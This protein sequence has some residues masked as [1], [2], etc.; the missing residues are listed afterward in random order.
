MLRLRRGRRRLQMAGR[1][2]RP[3]LSRSG[4]AAGGRSGR[5][6][7]QMDAGRRS[8][9]SQAQ[10]AV[11]HRR[12]RLRLLRRAVAHTRRRSGARLSGFARARRGGDQEIPPGLCAEFEHGADPASAGQKR[13]AGRHGGGRRGAACGRR[14]AGARLLLQPHDVSDRRS[15]RPCGRVRR[16]RARSRRQAQISQHGRDDALLQRAHALQFRDRAGRRHQ[17]RHDRRRR[18]L[19]GRDRAGAGGLRGGRRASWAPRSPKTS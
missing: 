1:D 17:G 14:T 12:A 5:R 3:D 15:A 7:S 19:Y 18:R 11:R 2:G 16:A 6:T 10:D 9:R 4:R 13:A 8:A